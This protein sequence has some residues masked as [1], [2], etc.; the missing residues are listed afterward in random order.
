MPEFLTCCHEESAVAMAHGYYKIEGRPM[1]A[2]LHGTVG[3]QHAP[4]RSTTPTPT[5][6]LYI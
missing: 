2:L 6:Y 3:L 4:W 5:A 1:M